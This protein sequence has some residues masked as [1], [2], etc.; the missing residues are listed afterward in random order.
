MRKAGR[1]E[2]RNGGMEE[3]RNGMEEWRKGGMEE[4]RNGGMEEWRNGGMEECPLPTPTAC[5][6]IAQGHAARPW[7]TRPNP[8]PPQRGGKPFACRVFSQPTRV[9]TR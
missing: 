2:R 9:L 6:V 3:W 5:P 8:D 1:Q 4:W 7:G